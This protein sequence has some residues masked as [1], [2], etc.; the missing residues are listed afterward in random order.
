MRI[1]LSMALFLT[2]HA[3]LAPPAIAEAWQREQ[4]EGV[5]NAK[6][7][8]LRALADA[9]QV[10]SA[11][12]DAG[13]WIVLAEQLWIH[14]GIYARIHPALAEDALSTVYAHV[15]KTCA[16]D[17]DNEAWR[18]VRALV[19]LARQ[20]AAWLEGD[21]PVVQAAWIEAADV[22]AHEASVRR[23]A[24]NALRA[25]VSLAEIAGAK[26]ADAKD[27]LAR[28][29][30][31]F[32]SA[33]GAASGDVAKATMT[34]TWHTA[35]ARAHLAAR[36]KG[37]AKAALAEAL[38]ALAPH[39]ADP[40]D[41]VAK[42]V[43]EIATLARAGRVKLQDADVPTQVKHHK[44]TGLCQ[45]I[46]GAPNWSWLHDDHSAILRFERRSS[47]GHR[48][49]IVSVRGWSKDTDLRMMNGETVL[50]ANTKELAEAEA[51]T[52]EQSFGI[53][54]GENEPRI[55]KAKFA[56]AYA[57]GYRLELTGTSASL[58]VP[59]RVHV[60]YVRHK[61]AQMILKVTVFHDLMVDLDDGTLP[62]L[63]SN[64]TWTK[65]EK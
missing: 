53:D 17:P 65:P 33:L 45:T 8:A 43:D 51:K 57:D 42:A 30:T 50:V 34:A 52:P 1:V 14:V 32:D 58:K 21:R 49:Y 18:L 24:A 37:A 19:T 13:N 3:L 7:G 9:E 35:V 60:Y 63:F 25:A 10:A 28:A 56:R 16:A 48:Y 11:P 39:R 31:H 46:G 6:E 62:W 2:A 55:K 15:A 20:R 44:R 59:R 64:L 38:A 4:A 41:D 40:P 47:V 29:R 54:I 5:M 23:A 12:Q 36:S 22:L 26:K 61:K 27:L